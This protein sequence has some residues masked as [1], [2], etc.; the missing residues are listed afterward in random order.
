TLRHADNGTSGP[1]LN[2]D[3]IKHITEHNYHVTS[4]TRKEG[5]H[6]AS[7]R[8]EPDYSAPLPSYMGPATNPIPGAHKSDGFDFLK[9][10]STPMALNHTTENKA[11]VEAHDYHATNAHQSHDQSSS[12]SHDSSSHGDHGHSDT[13]SDHKGSPHQSISQVADVG[14]EKTSGFGS[15]VI[16][17]LVI[18][19]I[20]IL[21][22]FISIGIVKFVP[23]AI[24]SLSS[25]SV[26]LT[27]LFSKDGIELVVDKP[28]IKSGETL[29]ISWKNT[30]EK[31]GLY[32]WTFKCTDGV[33]V[34]YRSMD[35]SMKPVICE[36]SFPIPENATSYPFVFKSLQTSNVEVPMTLSLFEKDTKALLYS[37]SAEVTIVTESSSTETPSTSTNN[38]P[39]Y[40]PG[41]GSPVATSTAT[42]TST[43]TSTRPTTSRPNTPVTTS[44][45][46]A[47]DMSI[48]LVQANSIES[49]T[50]NL[51]DLSNVGANDKVVIRFRVANQ[52][53]MATG[54]W[55]ITA[56]LPTRIVA[57]QAFASG[58]Q[59]S[60]QPGVSHEMT[61][62]FDSYDSSKNQISISLEHA[63]DT[64]SSNNLL[65]IPISG[66]Y[67]G[68]TG[69]TGGRAD[70]AVNIIDVGVMDIMGNFYH[71]NSISRFDKVAVKFE[72][73][74]KGGTGTGYWSMRADLPTEAGDYQI[75][76]PLTPLS[77][78][79]K[80]QF[81]LGFDNPDTGNQR[82]T[83][84]ADYRDDVSESSESNNT[85]SQSI[86]IR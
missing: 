19:G 27:N 56:V 15:K 7:S 2:N 34:L 39:S 77:A 61:M 69:N 59:P 65:T 78:G 79:Q 36:T 49:G 9:N 63:N 32:A 62:M 68:S 17:V 41:T 8:P 23:K 86:Y 21:L 4:I 45:V 67:N 5:L 83:I 31:T 3:G 75:Y 58:Q 1:V 57:D 40:N 18:L 25:A 53:T 6:E 30:S 73:E 66:S 16:K 12:K 76:G 81:T 60:L 44:P 37:D 14:Q 72:V 48:T 82:I 47:T 43:G 11:A 35:G 80:T 74:N 46:G 20:L 70:L 85:V 33:S 54:P 71:S 29:T 26:Y 52:G 22:F 38:T 84:R 51:R 24:G 13:R 55:R 42:S 10:N 50:I 64:N 28:E